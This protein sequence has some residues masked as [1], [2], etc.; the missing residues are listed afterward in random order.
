MS[1]IIQ[2]EGTLSESFPPSD[3]TIPCQKS[4]NLRA[5]SQNPFPPLTVLIRTMFDE[6]SSTSDHPKSADFS[7]H[8]SYMSGCRGLYRI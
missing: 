2:S 8:P 3:R 1:E 7:W 6:S 4:S 5:P